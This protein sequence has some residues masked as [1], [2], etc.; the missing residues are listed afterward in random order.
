MNKPK[1][2]KE[3][4]KHGQ[5]SEGMRSISASREDTKVR[6]RFQKSESY[7][8]KKNKYFFLKF[9]GSS[10]TSLSSGL[11][12]TARYLECIKKHQIFSIYVFCFGQKVGIFVY[13]KYLLAFFFQNL[14]TWLTV[15]RQHWKIGKI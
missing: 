6:E 4:P 15:F 13:H 8:L 2:M 9:Q 5:S 14:N 12:K 3:K 7:I 11:P 10:S 1:R